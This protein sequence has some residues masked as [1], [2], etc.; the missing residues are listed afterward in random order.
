MEQQRKLFQRFERKLLS[1]IGLLTGVSVLL[2][3]AHPANAGT[4]DFTQT[5]FVNLN[6]GPITANS[7]G[8]ATAPST[9]SIN[10]SATVNF[11]Q[12]LNATSFGTLSAVEIGFNSILAGSLT[13]SADENTN[14]GSFG[15]WKGHVGASIPGLI[16]S[17]SQSFSVNC[18]ANSCTTTFGPVTFPEDA[19][20][21]ILTGAAMAPYVGAGNVTASELLSIVISANNLGAGGVQA[22]GSGTFDPPPPEGIT[23]TYVYTTPSTTPEPGTLA[24]L[25]MGAAVGLGF[26]RRRLKQ[27]G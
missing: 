19:T 3:A 8:N 6:V 18:A 7:P 23:V 2:P 4:I 14:N 16:F 26:A 24:L 1:Q 21:Q 9:V 20:T 22:S 13:L 27:D 11:A 12:T 15:T 25:G 5:K 10:A 17:D